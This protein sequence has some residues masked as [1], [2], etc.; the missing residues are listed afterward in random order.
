MK[1]VIN[2][3]LAAILVSIALSGCGETEAPPVFQEPPLLRTEEAIINQAMVDDPAAVLQLLP[4]EHLDFRELTPAAVQG[5]F[6]LL[7]VSDLQAN[8]E[9]LF[10]SLSEDLG[11]TLK[12]PENVS[13]IAFIRGQSETGHFD[14]TAQPILNNPLGIQAVGFQSVNYTTT[15]PLPD[16]ER[17]FQV[18]GGLLVPQDIDKTQLKGVVVYFHGT[19]FNNSQVG[20]DVG[21]PETQLCAQVF[22]S[23]GYAVLI[24]DY[25]GQGVDWQ[26][27]HPYVAYPKVS[28]QTAVDM[29]SAAKP[30][31]VDHFGLQE[32][33]PPLKLFSA[34]Y[35]EG[36]AY[37]LWFNS[38]LATNPGRLDPL[39][40]LIHSV[41]MEGAYST[42]QVTYD[43]LFNNVSVSG[44]NPFN[45]Q[46]EILVSI[47][48]PAL[49]ANALLSYATYSTNSDFLA[50]FNK[51]FFLMTATPPVPQMACNVNGQQ[52][53]I[54]W[55][56]TQPDTDIS[57]QL[58]MSGLGKMANQERYPGPFELLTSS[59]NNIRSL[60]SP[61]LLVPEAL[62]DL[63]AVLKAADVDLS[64][65]PDGAVSIITLAQDSVVVP[66]NF[67]LLASTYP[68]KLR[69]TIKIDHN[70]IL[71]VSVFS[72]LLGWPYWIP[73]DH[74]QAPVYQFL[75]T[76]QIFN[77]LQ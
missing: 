68:S 47:V 4:T 51:N 30:V 10:G 35:S 37:S 16:G 41:G 71:T 60:I 76:L 40:Q 61:Y 72:E 39:Y 69:S 48:K 73:I 55:A 64:P 52:V 15:V 6:A 18:S 70:K 34:G 26:N 27:V 56:F 32:S 31:F 63:Q 49:S 54:A 12:S 20:S 22:A 5:Q 38:Y 67:D 66:N 50:I 11:V 28:A 65:C 24:P 58:V 25:V 19:T 21:N 44:G 59:N 57:A 43:F 1:T 2:R 3:L 23:Q 13:N 8:Y 17:S 74:L 62:A 46:S 45:V 9:T 36:G 77:E 53:D 75:Y 29:L 7:P 14:L 42:S 33:D